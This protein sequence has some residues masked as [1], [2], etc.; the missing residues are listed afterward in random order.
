MRIFPAPVGGVFDRRQAEILAVAGTELGDLAVA[1][2]DI[3]VAV[4]GQGDAPGKVRSVLQVGLARPITAVRGL[5]PDQAVV[6]GIQDIEPGTPG[7]GLGRLEGIGS[8]MGGAPAVCP[9]GVTV[10]SRPFAS[11]ARRRLSVRKEQHR[12]LRGLGDHGGHARMSRW[13][14]F[15]PCRS[16]HRP[17]FQTGL[18]I[19][20]R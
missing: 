19:L 10:R 4:H 20:G 8:P 6:L 9:P 12:H 13:R 1:T 11:M 15:R 14:I 5:V 17:R 3:E 16:G 18:C 7:D 2:E